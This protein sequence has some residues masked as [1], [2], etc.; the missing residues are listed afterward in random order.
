MT[1]LGTAACPRGALGDILDR[2]IGKV[3][4]ALIAAGED[5]DADDFDRKV[6]TRL[7]RGAYPTR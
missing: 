6:R 2:W 4:D 3:E 1:E 7:G 5:E